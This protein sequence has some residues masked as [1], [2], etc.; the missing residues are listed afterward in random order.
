MNLCETSSFWDKTP[1]LRV[2]KGVIGH[3]IEYTIST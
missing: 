1:D 3:V 2:K